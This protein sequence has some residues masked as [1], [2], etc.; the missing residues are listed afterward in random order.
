MDSNYYAQIAA[1][2]PSIA[3]DEILRLEQDVIRPLADAHKMYVH[4]T[5]VPW[6]PIK[7][8]GSVSWNF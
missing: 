8:A 2:D 1:E 5:D 4:E 6:R 7:S 3:S